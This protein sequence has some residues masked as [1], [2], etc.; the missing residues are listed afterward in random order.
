VR[1]RAFTSRDGKKREIAGD[2]QAV[3]VTISEAEDSGLQA[4]EVV[5]EING[6]LEM[7]EEYFVL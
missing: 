1:A 4:H 7:S 3:M 5:H 6:V 2:Q